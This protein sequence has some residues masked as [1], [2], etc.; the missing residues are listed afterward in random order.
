VWLE[1]GK[2]GPKGVEQ[3]VKVSG[4]ALNLVEVIG[5]AP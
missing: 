5:V 2:T 1:F 3:I 4:G